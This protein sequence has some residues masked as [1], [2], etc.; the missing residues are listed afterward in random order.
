M[1]HVVALHRQPTPTGTAVEDGLLASPDEGETWAEAVT[2]QC[3]DEVGE[4]FAL[5]PEFVWFRRGERAVRWDGTRLSDDGTC[6]QVLATLLLD[7]HQR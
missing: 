7:W 6:K 5:G 1:A 3:P 2:G 4:L